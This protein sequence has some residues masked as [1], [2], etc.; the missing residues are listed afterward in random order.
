M[1][2]TFTLYPIEPF[3]LDYTVFALRRKSK[4]KVD[5]W[6]DKRYFRLL[7]IENEPVKVVVIQKTES[8]LC[9]RVNKKLNNRALEKLSRQLENLLGLKR[10]L[11]DFYQLASQDPLLSPLVRRFIG[12]KPPQFPSLFEALVN[13]ISCQQISLDAG[14][15]IQNRLVESFGKTLD[16]DDRVM[17][18]FPSP[19]EI[20]NCSIS[21]LKKLGYSTNKSET[22]IGLA[23]AM[24][25]SAA[26]AGL[27]NKSN[28]EVISFLCHLKGI[29]RWTAEYVL[30][31]GL[32]RIEVFPSDDV[33]AQNNLS[34]L[35]HLDNKV[36]YKKISAIIAKWHPYAGLVY[37]HLL[38]QKLYK[39][40]A[41]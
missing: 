18:A 13:A 15:Q 23:S 6:D 38:L 33:G 3:R 41:I 28:D 34:H 35:L 10:N 31:R 9:V 21:Q 37:F 19:Y 7:V 27:A 25:E 2:S 22:L 32:G 4:N 5:L 11:Q 20:R 40:G 30:L 1:N 14:L 29:G 12:L 39:K 17:Y 24:T 26:F 16:E 36:D 8:Q